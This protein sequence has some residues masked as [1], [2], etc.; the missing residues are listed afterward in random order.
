M[1]GVDA[2]PKLV[3]AQSEALAGAR[4]AELERKTTRAKAV[5]DVNQ[6][7]L[8]VVYQD[9]HLVQVE[10]RTAVGGWSGVARAYTTWDDLRALAGMAQQFAESLGAPVAWEAGE[11]NGIGLVGLSFYTI[12]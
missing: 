3:V 9:E 7:S 11:D 8:S 4:A 5:D 6:L 10:C 1:S 12:D 2:G